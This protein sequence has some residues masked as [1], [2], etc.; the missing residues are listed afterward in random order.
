M[1]AIHSRG[2]AGG[3]KIEMRDVR[4]QM[5]G[6]SAEASSLTRALYAAKYGG[7]GFDYILNIILDY[8]S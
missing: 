2:D 4:G 6:S 7:P 8:V 5:N 3:R 1:V